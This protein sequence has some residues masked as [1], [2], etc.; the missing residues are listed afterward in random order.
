VSAYPYAIRYGYCEENRVYAP[1]FAAALHL[2]K[3]LDSYYQAGVGR[4]N[5]VS[6]VNEDR[7][8]DGGDGL[9]EDEKLA[10]IG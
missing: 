2:A 3:M 5:S 10:W 8:T 4:R 1:N 9:T 7:A 6:I